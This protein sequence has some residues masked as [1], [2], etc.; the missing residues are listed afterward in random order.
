MMEYC[1][2]L[3]ACEFRKEEKYSFNTKNRK[4]RDIDTHTRHMRLQKYD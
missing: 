1:L 4:K 2:I 3:N